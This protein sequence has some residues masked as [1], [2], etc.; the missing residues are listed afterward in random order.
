V[1]D[2]VFLKLQPY[3]QSSV[4]RRAN[5]KLSFKFSAPIV[6]LLVLEKSHTR[7]SCR[8]A[9]AFSFPC[10]TAQTLSAAYSEGAH[11]VAGH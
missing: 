8:R 9:V 3:V 4:H 1:G 10:L 11:R 6:F 2:R 7:F 5:H